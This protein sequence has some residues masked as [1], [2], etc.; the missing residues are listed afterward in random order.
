MITKKEGNDRVNIGDFTGGDISNFLLNDDIPY[1]QYDTTDENGEGM[2][3]ILQR[4]GTQRVQLGDAFSG[5]IELSLKDSQLYLQHGYTDE[6]ENA[7][8][9]ILQR[10][11]S[12]R[13]QLGD[14]F[15]GNLLGKNI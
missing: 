15:S 3:A 9:T 4:D 5:S 11:N 7:M 12:Q 6:N 10:N 1:I 8:T 14:A 13:V 2:T